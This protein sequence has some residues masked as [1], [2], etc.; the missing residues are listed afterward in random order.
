VDRLAGQVGWCRAGANAK[1]ASWNVHR[2]EEPPISGWAGSGTIFFSGCTARCLFCQNYPI[3]QLGVGDEV[4]PGRLAQMMLELQAKG[5]HNINLVTPTHYVPQFL[6]ALLLAVPAG[7]R[8]PIVYNTSGYDTV[9]TLQL[10]DG[11][12]DL[13]LPDAKYG[14]DRVAT[15]LS[16]FIGYVAANR[17]ALQEM[18]RQVGAELVLDDLGIAQRGMIIRHLV[19]PNGLSQTAA[20]LPWLA[21]HLSPRVWVSLMDQY[22]PAHR[23]VNHPE[24]GRRITPAEYQTAIDAFHA[25]GLENGWIQE[26]DV[27]G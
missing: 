14:D 13:Y 4:T 23:A 24:L 19:L 3:S 18:L 8:V 2:W 12:V 10:L 21:Q 1:V 27:H 17:A 22:F 15:R 5:V 25:A 26:H 20:V 11:I 16:G 7:L 6:Q 9:D